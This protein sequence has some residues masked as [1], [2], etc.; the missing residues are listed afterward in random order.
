M[1]P[2]QAQHASALATYAALV[3]R[4]FAAQA[5]AL[6]VFGPALDP[7]PPAGRLLDSAI[8]VGQDDLAPLRALAEHGRSLAADGFAAP[9]VLTA[10]A[11]DRAR[12]TFPL[13][14][15]DLTQRRRLVFGEDPFLGLALDPAHL[16]LQCERELR[17]LRIAL[18]QRLLQA[19]GA[20]TIPCAD[21]VADTAR[22]LRGLLHGIG[23]APAGPDVAVLGTAEKTWSLDLA[24]L[25]QALAGAD[26]WATF[27]AV[28]G[29]VGALAAIADRDAAR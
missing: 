24:P 19:G 7:H 10:Q 27:Q 4:A 20:S 6:V 5:R 18:R 26:D 13:E 15:L 2:M 11:I 29:V 9:L 28:Y 21:L 23:A 1:S 16:R 22:V 8:I 3:R 14:L 12:D 17:S 25:R